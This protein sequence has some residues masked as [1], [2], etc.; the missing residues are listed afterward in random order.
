MIQAFH[1]NQR[2]LLKSLVTEILDIDGESSY[3]TLRSDNDID[4]E[5]SLPVNAYGIFS[6]EELVAYGSFMV[7]SESDTK[8][9]LKKYEVPVDSPSSEVICLT[10]CLVHP[11]HRG[12]GYQTMLL[13]HREQAALSLRKQHVYVVVEDD[14]RASRRNISRMGYCAVGTRYSCNSVRSLYYKSLHYHNTPEGGVEE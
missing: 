3:L 11:K 8:R 13:V 12:K 4:W 6:G 9:F 7:P 14:N 5:F 2:H 1:P 10:N